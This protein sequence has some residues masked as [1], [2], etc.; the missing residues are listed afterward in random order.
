[1][2][3]RIFFIVKFATVKFPNIVKFSMVKFPKFIIDFLKILKNDVEMYAFIAHG[4]LFAV[5]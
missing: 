5:V 2:I 4:L 3:L 1:M